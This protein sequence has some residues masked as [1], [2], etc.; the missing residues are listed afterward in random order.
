MFGKE[1]GWPQCLFFFFKVFCCSCKIQKEKSNTLPSPAKYLFGKIL[2][3]FFEKFLYIYTFVLTHAESLD[4]LPRPF[5]FLR[6]EK[7]IVSQ[8]SSFSE[9]RFNC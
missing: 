9:S 5:F 4:N 6:I 2:P 1:A 7:C 3:V 8:M